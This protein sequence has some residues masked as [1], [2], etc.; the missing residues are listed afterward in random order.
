MPHPA[1]LLHPSTA[2]PLLRAHAAPTARTLLDVLA[3]TTA[4]HPDALALD[5]GRTRLTYVEL[6]AAVQ[7]VARRLA[8]RGVGPGSAVGV[9]IPSG[10]LELYVSILGVL[11]AGAAAAGAPPA[12]VGRAR[13]RRCDSAR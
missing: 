9:R 5:D 1:T 10:G 6:A 12:R 2:S 8:G 7:G 4:A 11:A 13:P 3:T